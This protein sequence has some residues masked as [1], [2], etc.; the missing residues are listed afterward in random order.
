MQSMK[1]SS[2]LFISFLRIVL[3]ESPDYINFTV[4]RVIESYNKLNHTVIHDLNLAIVIA[5]RGQN[6]H[7]KNVGKVVKKKYMSH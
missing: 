7:N 1:T 4:F 2:V 5:K 3:K 6:C